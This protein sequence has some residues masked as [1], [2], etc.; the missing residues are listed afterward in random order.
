M[1]AHCKYS[2]NWES[3]TYTT[4]IDIAHI[5]NITHEIQLLAKVIKK[6]DEVFCFS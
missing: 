2:Y 3:K 6:R 1:A 5:T 4:E